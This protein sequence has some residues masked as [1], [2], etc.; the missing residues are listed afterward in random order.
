MLMQPKPHQ[1]TQVPTDKELLVNNI[2]QSDEAQSKKEMVLERILE[3]LSDIDNEEADFHESID[4]LS[5][6]IATLY[7]FLKDTKELDITA[8]DLKSMVNALIDAEIS[9]FSKESS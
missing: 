4:Y 9:K 1:V 8:E 2:H 3:L 6:T 7:A 5:S